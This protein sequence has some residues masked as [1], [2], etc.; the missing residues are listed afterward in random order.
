[1]PNIHYIPFKHLSN[2]GLSFN[3]DIYLP[4][5]EPAGAIVATVSQGCHVAHAPAIL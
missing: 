4:T 1:M 3:D 2:L 5:S